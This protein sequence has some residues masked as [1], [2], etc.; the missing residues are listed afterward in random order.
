ML[1]TTVG[2]D[3]NQQH[4]LENAYAGECA[5]VIIRFNSFAQTRCDSSFL[6]PITGDSFAATVCDH[7]IRV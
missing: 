7:L 5:C 2:G 6:T 4:W 3:H 1:T